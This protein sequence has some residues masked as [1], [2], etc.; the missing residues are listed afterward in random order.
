LREQRKKRT[1]NFLANTKIQYSRVVFMIDKTLIDYM[2]NPFII[3]IGL[4]G[5]FLTIAQF[6]SDSSIQEIFFYSSGTILIIF[7]SAMINILTDFK[8]TKKVYKE[9]LATLNQVIT[10]KDKYKQQFN[11]QSESYSRKIKEN[12]DLKVVSVVVKSIV[13]SYNPKSNDSKDLIRLL[14]TSLEVSLKKGSEK[15]EI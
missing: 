4:I 1:N 15:D 14:K 13:E 7:L 9:N 5:S 10:E 2:K 6:F 3:I 8:K 12:E 11:K